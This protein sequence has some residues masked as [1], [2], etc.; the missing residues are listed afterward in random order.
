MEN[1]VQTQ[2]TAL[3]QS[4]IL[5]YG[6][7]G[8]FLNTFYL[9]FLAYNRLFYLTNVLQLSTGVS[10]LVNSLAVW[11]NVVTMILAGG[12][13]DR[14]NFKKWGKFCGWAVIG[15]TAMSVSLPLLFSDLGL[16]QAAAGALFVALFVVQSIAYNCLWV[17]ERSLVGPLSHSASDANGLAMA[18]QGQHAGRSDLRCRKRADYGLFGGQLYDDRAD[19]R[20]VYPWRHHRYVFPDQKVRSSQSGG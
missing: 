18:A 20:P 16:S 13:V 4:Q 7:F 5:L 8:M 1:K 12:I 11:G 19:L 9:M 17:A 3:K 6:F 10:A 15:G 14:I 2:T